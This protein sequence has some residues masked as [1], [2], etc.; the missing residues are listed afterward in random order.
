MLVL[1]MSKIE[2]LAEQLIVQPPYACHGMKEGSVVMVNAS[3]SI[4]ALK[5]LGSK[6]STVTLMA[7]DSANDRSHQIRHE[8]RTFPI[9]N[10]VQTSQFKQ[11][12]ELNP[13]GQPFY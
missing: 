6:R 8:E 13:K 1:K 7:L 4:P 10:D 11:L 12:P 9:T 2:V 3:I 5:Y